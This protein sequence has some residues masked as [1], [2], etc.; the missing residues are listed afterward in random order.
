MRTLIYG[1]SLQRKQENRY[2]V[3]RIRGQRRI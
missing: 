3:A 2:C 1:E